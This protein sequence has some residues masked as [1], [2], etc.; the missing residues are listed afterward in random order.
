MFKEDLVGIIGAEYVTDD[1]NIREKY[2]QDFSF[3]PPRRPNYVVY[4]A[5]TEEV[6]AVVRFANQHSIAITPRSSAVSF[7]GA[8][9]PSQGGILMDL[10]RMNKILEIDP[11]DRKVKVEP[12]VTWSQVQDEL[13]KH[14]MMVS[15]PLLPH[16][17]KSVLTSTMQREP[18]VIPKPEYNETF[19]AGEIVIGSGELFWMGT[20]IAKGMV[21]RCNPEA[22]LLGTRLFHGHQGTLGIVTW[23]NIKA[24]FIPRMDKLFFIPC[25]KIEDVAPPVYRIQRL[26]LGSECLVLNNFNLASILAQKGVGEFNALREAL[27]PY[28][29]ILCLSG[30][31]RQPEGRIEYE[32]EALM[33]AA[34]EL[35]FKPEHTLAGIQG[36]D[37][38]ILKMLRKPWTGDKYWKFYPKGACSDI[39]FNATLNR[40]SEFTKAMS[41]VA[42]KYEYSDREIGI[43]LQP[44]ERARIC[45]HQFSFYYDPDNESDKERVRCLFLEASKM[46]TDMG[47]LFTN[48]YGPWADMVFSRAAT[49]TMLMRS[50]KAAFDPNNIMNPG[51]LCF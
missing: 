41:E 16:P 31:R 10:G 33:T 42:A 40:A 27:P 24:E 25:H 39:F 5:N 50:I 14:G 26:M 13:K 51:K 22:F 37:L 11:K 30:L 17:G 3:V 9:I 47:G 4:P 34:S 21:G 45:Y 20:A 6:Q 19:M 36:L 35:G 7:Y 23:A 38:V 28:T 18:M 32:E 49:F 43:Y 46:V 44:I 8:S 29:V 15:G 1:T 12:G 2:A 48:P